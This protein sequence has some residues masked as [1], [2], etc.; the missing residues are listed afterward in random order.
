MYRKGKLGKMGCEKEGGGK[1]RR[2][3]P[4]PDFDS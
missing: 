1:S 2:G 4:E 3:K